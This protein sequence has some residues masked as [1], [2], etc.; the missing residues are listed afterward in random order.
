[1]S[2]GAAEVRLTADEIADVMVAEMRARL[3]TEF[4]MLSARFE[5]DIRQQVRK[6]DWPAGPATE[7]ATDQW[8]R[9]A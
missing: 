7:A 5:I 3:L 1:M 4:L 6:V 2:A 8:T 9:P